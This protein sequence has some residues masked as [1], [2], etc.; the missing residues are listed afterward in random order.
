MPSTRSQTA[1]QTHSS[2]RAAI[3][4][5]QAGTSTGIKRRQ[6]KA[7]SKTPGIPKSPQ[8]E[9]NKAKIRL[10]LWNLVEKYFP[11][12]KIALEPFKSS[13]QT[14]VFA[15]IAAIMNIDF[16]CV[17]ELHHILMQTVDSGRNFSQL[18]YQACILTRFHGLQDIA[19]FG[20]KK[21]F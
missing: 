7:K 17:L 21:R 15:I 2:G 16:I 20:V 5:G 18:T 8:L 12:L 9:N 13:N 6:V 11:L 10:I 4:V 3:P 14:T 19:G 1:R